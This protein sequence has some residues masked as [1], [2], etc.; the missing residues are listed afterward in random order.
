MTGTGAKKVTFEVWRGDAASAL[1]GIAL[2]FV[3][4][5]YLDWQ[6]AVIASTNAK[7][8]GVRGPAG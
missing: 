8:Q 5:R 4:A 1:A 7:R 3:Y 6:A 2:H